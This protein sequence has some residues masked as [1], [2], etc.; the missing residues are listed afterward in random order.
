VFVGRF[1]TPLMVVTSG[2]VSAGM[3][4]GDL[5][6]DGSLSCSTGGEDAAT[7]GSVG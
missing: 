4:A 5:D 1:A 3:L 2:A 7:D 6:C